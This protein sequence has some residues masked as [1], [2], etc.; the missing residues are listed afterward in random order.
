MANH[1]ARE[2][3]SVRIGLIAGAAGTVVLNT[4]GYLDMLVRG[5]AASTAPAQAARAALEALGGAVPGRGGEQANRQEALG[6]LAGIGAGLGV[7]VA[8]AL[9]RTVGFRPGPVAGSALT[10]AAAMLATDGPMAALGVSD[11]RTWSAADWTSDVVPHLAY[12]AAVHATIAG[13][14]GDGEPGRH[15]ARPGLVARSALL[16]LAAGSRT[17]LGLLGPVLTSPTASR[18]ARRA[19][20]LGIAS[21]LVGD[22]LPSTPSRLEPGARY[23]RLAAGAVCAVTLAGRESAR[24]LVPALAGLAGASAGTWGGAAWRAWAVRRMP[25]WRA[26]LLEDA[27]AL[28]AAG[29]ALS[30][31]RGAAGLARA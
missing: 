12:G 6:A 24:P 23:G 16:G 14:G 20:G 28:T 31:G 15:R 2:R 3:S 8:A 30:T 13:S 26:A 25:D 7:G 21:E 27:V 17:T 19:A 5:R 11:P 29:L 18:A 10:G 22:K 9:A 4:V 1:W